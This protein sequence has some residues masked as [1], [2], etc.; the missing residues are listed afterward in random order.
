M[1]EDEIVLSENKSVSRHGD[2]VLRPAG[3][4]TPSVQALLRHFR[5][6]G[7]TAL[8]SVLGS[9]VDAEGRETLKRRSSKA[10]R[11]TAEARYGGWLGRPARRLGSCGIGSHCGKRLRNRTRT[12]RKAPVRRRRDE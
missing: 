4:W 8:P 11:R 7:L 3:P 12:C 2:T 6:Q 9:G 10:L 1:N 5:N